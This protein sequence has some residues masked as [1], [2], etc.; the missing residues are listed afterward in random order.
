MVLRII[1]ALVGEA[2]IARLNLSSLQGDFG[3]QQL[4]GKTVAVVG[5]ARLGGRA[6]Q[7]RIV[8]QLLTISGEDSSS[9][10]RKHLPVWNGKLTT[11]LVLATNELP[12]LH[13]ASGAL[14]RRIVL[15][16]F[17]RRVPEDKVDPH[18]S[19]KLAAEVPGI[20]WWAIQGLQRLKQTGRFTRPE[21]SRLALGQPARPDIAHG[22]VHP[23]RVHHGPGGRSSHRLRVSEI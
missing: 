3:Q 6:D 22:G 4:I 20:F 1:N 12:K 19:R 8:E 14:L 17:G 23:R 9:I 16:R 10:S 18:L 11:R 21:S 5:D 13:D 2:N 7:A 15:I